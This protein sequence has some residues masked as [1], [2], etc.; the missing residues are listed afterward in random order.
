M[1]LTFNQMANRCLQAELTDIFKDKEQGDY[2]TLIHLLENGAKG[3]FNMEPSELIEEYN[4][5]EDT[6]YRLHEDQELAI[7][8]LDDD[9]INHIEKVI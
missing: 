9:P 1:R 8:T 2:D 6:W 7:S 3:Y 4:C 5:M